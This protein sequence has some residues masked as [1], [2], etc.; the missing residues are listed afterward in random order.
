MSCPVSLHV[1]VL[2]PQHQVENQ[3]RQAGS[4]SFVAHEGDLCCFAAVDDEVLCVGLGMVG[5]D[6]LFYCNW[7]QCVFA[8]G[9]LCVGTVGLAAAGNETSAAP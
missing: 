9:A 3:K 1:Y 6:E 2:Q 7:A 8:V 4:K 5:F